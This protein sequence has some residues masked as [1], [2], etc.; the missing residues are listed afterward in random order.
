MSYCYWSWFFCKSISRIVHSLIINLM[1]LRQPVWVHPSLLLTADFSIWLPLTNLLPTS[2]MQEK[3]VISLL[4]IW[5]FFIVY[6]TE[7]SIYILF[8]VILLVNL[9]FLIF[10]L[11]SF[12]QELKKTIMTKQQWLYKALCVCNKK[13]QDNFE[14]Q[15]KIMTI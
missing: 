14:I 6:L 5:S 13:D 4:Y 2:L 12:I 9:L 1:N 15:K 11:Y 7:A 3:I 10:W 8:S